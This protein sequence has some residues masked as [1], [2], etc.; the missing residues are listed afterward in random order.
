VAL[1][2]LAD[3]DRP[4]LL[5]KERQLVGRR[6]LVD[7]RWRRVVLPLREALAWKVL[8]GRQVADLL[9]LVERQEAVPV[10]VE[11]VEQEVGCLRVVLRPR[12]VGQEL[13][14][15]LL[16]QLAVLVG[17]GE[18]ERR[19][20]VG[21]RPGVRLLPGHRLGVDEQSTDARDQEGESRKPP[22]PHIV[23]LWAQV[24]TE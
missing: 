7:R 24:V 20:G 8:L 1:V 17:V 6:F 2:A 21:E 3:E 13:L 12:R 15:L 11:P 22:Q 23:Q 14:E 9:Q 10:L 19:L 4:N 18:L 5:L 16:R